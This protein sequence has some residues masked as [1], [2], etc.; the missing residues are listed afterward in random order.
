MHAPNKNGDLPIHLAVGD[1]QLV[2][3]LK[4]YGADTS[5]TGIQLETLIH[6]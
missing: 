2:K 3:I 6:T 1:L 5:A 4:M